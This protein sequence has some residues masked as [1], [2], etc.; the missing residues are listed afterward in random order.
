MDGSATSASPVTA[1]RANQISSIQ[2]PAMDSVNTIHGSTGG[3]GRDISA[4]MVGDNCTNLVYFRS[5]LVLCLLGRIPFDLPF[6]VACSDDSSLQSK[7]A[8]GS[9]PCEENLGRTG[10]RRRLTRDVSPALESALEDS[11]A[12]GRAAAG[13]GR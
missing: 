7:G 8:S 13:E 6:G 5:M 10:P 12:G 1:M 2:P 9:C 11:S 4:T 3:T